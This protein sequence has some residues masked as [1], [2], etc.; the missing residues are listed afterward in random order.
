MAYLVIEKEHILNK[1][2]LEQFDICRIMVKMA[3]RFPGLPLGPVSSTINILHHRALFV[4]T[5]EPL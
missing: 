2:V 1:Q 3:Q 4:T 5:H